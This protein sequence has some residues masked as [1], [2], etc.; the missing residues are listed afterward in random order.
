MDCYQVMVILWCLGFA[1]QVSGTNLKTV[2]F[3]Y[4][5]ANDFVG[6]KVP[7]VWLL[8]ALTV[9]GRKSW[10]TRP[11]VMM[12]LVFPVLTD[13]LNLTNSWHGLIYR[14]MWLDT[15]GS[16]PLLQ[17]ISGP[18]Y[19]VITAY[20]GILLL[21]VITVQ[22]KAALNRELLHREQGLAIAAATAAI[23]IF[24]ILCLITEGALFHYYDPT[25]VVI[26]IA[27]VFAGL[28]FRFRAQEAVPVPRNAVLEK[29]TGAVLI[30]DNRNRIMD[31]NPAAEAFSA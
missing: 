20:C 27:A 29:M 23:L 11:R 24:I 26:G 9:A 31:L 3:W 19:W 5:A 4:L 30:L 10:L 21:A 12:L 15:S 17:F 14:Q 6:L 8:W 18:W 25:P 22:V 13:I 7:V 28:V 1:L 16:Y 2:A